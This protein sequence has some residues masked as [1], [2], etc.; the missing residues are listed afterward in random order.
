VAY[1]AILVPMDSESVLAPSPALPPKKS[2]LGSIFSSLKFVLLVLGLTLAINVFGIQSYQVDGQSM[3][4]TLTNGD[5]LIISKLGRTKSS[6]LRHDFI[7]KR[8]DIIV[9]HDPFAEG[10]FLIKRVIALP[11]ER[12]TLQNGD[13][14]VYNS[15]HPEGYTPMDHIEKELLFTV[16]TVDLTVP[17]KQ[18]FVMGDNRGAGGSLDSRNYL[19]T[20][21]SK[22]VVG[23]LILR[24]FPL[25]DIHVF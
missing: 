8:G 13:L 24:L 18:L 17:D 9:F 10:R 20:V 14:R 15:E 6:L 5:R 7:P 25:S 16:G 23:V 21:P 4:P 22:E 11:G 19:G 12:V 2:R 3:Y 1:L